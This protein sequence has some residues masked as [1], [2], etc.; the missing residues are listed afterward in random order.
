MT[1][2]LYEI[3]RLNQA[4]KLIIDDTE[5]KIDSLFKFRL[6]GI[7]K[8]ISSHIENYEIIRAEKIKEFGKET[9]DGNI[10]IDPKDKKSVDKFSKEIKIIEDSDVELN[11][12]KFKVQDIFNKGV[13]ADVL[14]LL[15]PFVEE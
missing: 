1:V 7:M 12:K 6:L 11:I 5:N 8:E 10:G 15:Y 13:P 2:K 3:I 14:M 9:K 4:L